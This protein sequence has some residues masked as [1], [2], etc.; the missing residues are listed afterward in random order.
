MFGPKREL[1]E[2]GTD[3]QENYAEMLKG[4]KRRKVPWFW[5][6]FGLIFI[7]VCVW[8]FARYRKANASDVD[9]MATAVAEELTRTAG[10]TPT[11]TPEKTGAV[12]QTLTTTAAPWMLDGTPLPTKTPW[13]TLTPWWD[14]EVENG[15]Q[16]G[17]G[18]GP[19]Q[20]IPVTVIVP[21]RETVI[22]EVPVTVIVIHTV[23][24]DMPTATASPTPT[25]TQTPTTTPTLTPTLTLTSDL[26]ATATGTLTHT[27]TLT[28]SPTPTPTPSV[29]PVS[30]SDYTATPVAMPTDTLMPTLSPTPDNGR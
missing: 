4:Y 13:H 22:V 18:S 1:L 5:I 6:G 23:L 12:T 10:P 17:G 9:Q 27:L 7:L 26:T 8:T 11:W 24:P 29:T 2:P 3:P 21:V 15:G 19:A 30:D 25:E 28:P 14:E 20:A 16:P